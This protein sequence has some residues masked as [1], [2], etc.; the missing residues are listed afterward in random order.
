MSRVVAALLAAASCAPAAQ[1]EVPPSAGQPSIAPFTLEQALRAAGV[2]SPSVEA[3]DADLRAAEAGR[4]VARLKPNPEAQLEVENVAGSRSYSG[5]QSAETT[6]G[7]ALPIELGGK[8]SARVALADAQVDRA[9][10]AAAI[11]EAELQRRVTEAYIDT[12]SSERR[13]A[14]A[15]Q[16][17]DFAA[18]GFRA[19]TARVTA[20]AA[21]PIEQ[22]RADVI[23]I[24]ANLALEKAKREAEV[25][26]G[27]LARL[28]GQSVSG[29]LDDAW[30]EK[31]GTYGPAEPVAVERTLVY[32]AAQ[33]DFSAVSA[34]VGLARSQRVPDL[35][36]TAGARYFSDTNS[37]A[38]VVG[39]SLPLPFFNNGR[40][41]VDQAEA[42]ERAASS[43]RRVA[44]VEA[45]R[46]IA[47]AQA[48][49]AIAAANARAAGGPGLDAAMEAA[50][51]AAIG[52]ANGKFTQ[53]DLI[54]GQ[55][56]LAQTRA[57]Y[58]DALAEYHRAEALLMRLTAP[59]RN[60]G[61]QP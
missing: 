43:R 34:Q 31:I 46:E 18:A 54:E 14:I 9:R 51:I 45:E 20:G 32:A 37:T 26:R 47:E 3:A 50:R 6:A 56:T 11:A 53:L 35:T 41:S 27:S 36:L 1:A 15:Q 21:S 58:V 48:A 49:L 13:I 55:R 4:A 10:I 8:R 19:A 28:I 38:A 5:L 33:A 57:A 22:Q 12:A 2:A 42:L 61:D 16:E 7:I 39:L 25:A 23:R 40:A 59:A 30:F 17:A 29:P 24:N 60:S 52:Y 44:A